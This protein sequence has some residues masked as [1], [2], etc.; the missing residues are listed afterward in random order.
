MKRVVLIDDD[1]IFI[2]L[3]TRALNNLGYI[4]D[5]KKF[6]DSK[7]GLDYLTSL[8]T[9]DDN[10]PTML[11]VDINMPG[12]S[13]WDIV[14]SLEKLNSDAIRKCKVFILSSSLDGRD[15]EKALN[16]R[17]VTDFLMKPVTEAQLRLIAAEHFGLS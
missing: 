16:F 2:F 14:G 3:C 12:L 5:I 15:K 11:L 4:E 6:T 8:Q 17:L 9:D 1:D 10:F 7:K 13:G